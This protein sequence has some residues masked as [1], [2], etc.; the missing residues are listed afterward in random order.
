MLPKK[1]PCR[2][3][4][5]LVFLLNFF[6]AALFAEIISPAD[7]GAPAVSVSHADGKWII[8]GKKNVVT[9]ND[10]DLAVSIK[11]GSASWSMVPSGAKD[12]LV[13][14]G[15]RGFYVRLADAKKV[16]IVPYNT[17]LKSGVKT[18]LTAGPRGFFRKTLT[19]P[20]CL[21]V[22]LEGRDE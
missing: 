11:N 16:C 15:G 2:Q 1:F 21:T 13:K 8:A 6:S 4:A 9:L 12:M 7:W 3:L 20:L 14:T 17:G 18:S 19:L 10:S 22:C 5:A